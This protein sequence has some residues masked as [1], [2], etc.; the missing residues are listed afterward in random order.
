M[1]FLVCSD[2][3]GR[4]SSLIDMLERAHTRRFPADAV[5]FLGDGLRD[6]AYLSDAGLPIFRVAGNCDLFRTDAPDEELLT[7]DGYRILLTHGDR[8]SVK[9]GEERL[10]AAAAGKN[11]DIVLYGHTHVP[12]EHYYRAGETV[13]KSIDAFLADALIEVAEKRR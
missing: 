4:V 9:S 7:F 6:L 8:Y 1:R 5:F 2:S 3:H 12:S 13:S 10:I 11:A